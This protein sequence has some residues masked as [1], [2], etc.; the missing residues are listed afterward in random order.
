MYVPIFGYIFRF[1]LI[2]I[3]INTHSYLQ[4]LQ[5]LEILW[6]LVSP[7]FQLH[8]YIHQNLPTENDLRANNM[9][10]IGNCFEWQKYFK[11]QKNRFVHEVA[12][13]C[14]YLRDIYMTLLSRDGIQDGKMLMY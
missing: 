7:H 13:N 11:Q 5:R 4:S 14:T 8:I 12:V 10:R 1:L 3:S 6:L 9:Q 2:E